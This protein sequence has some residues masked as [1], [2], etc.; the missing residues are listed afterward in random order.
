MMYEFLAGSIGGIGGT[1]LTYPLDVLRVRL[2]L[3]PDATWTK[4]VNHGGLFQGLIPTLAGTLDE[5][6]CGATDY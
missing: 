5:L 4:A 2:A 1:L 6:K 3:L